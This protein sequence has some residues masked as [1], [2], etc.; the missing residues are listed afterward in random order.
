MILMMMMMMWVTVIS[1]CC[2]VVVV[3][4]SDINLDISFRSEPKDSLLKG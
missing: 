4:M 1:G 2:L 3:G